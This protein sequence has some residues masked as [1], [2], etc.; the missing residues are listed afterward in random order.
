MP[1][2]MTRTTTYFDKKILHLAKKEAI[3]KG[4]TLYQVLNEKLGKSFGVNPS[5][6]SVKIRPGFR[7]EDVFGTFDLG[8]RKQKLTR[9]DYYED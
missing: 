4:M 9:A 7:F 1:S 8:L 2:T 3:D 6:K 5:S